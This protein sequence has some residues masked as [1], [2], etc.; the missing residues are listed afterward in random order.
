L[1]YLLRPLLLL[2]HCNIL[3]IFAIGPPLKL[4]L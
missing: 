3:L 1:R 2:D 4:L